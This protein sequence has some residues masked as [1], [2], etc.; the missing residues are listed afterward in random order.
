MNKIRRGNRE[1]SRLFG[2][3]MV[4]PA[5]LLLVVVSII[6]LLDEILSSIWI[7]HSLRVCRCAVFLHIRNVDRLAAESGYPVQRRFQS[8]YSGAL[9]R[10]PG[11][12][13]YHLVL[14]AERQGGL[15]QYRAPE[16]RHD[17]RTDL[18]SVRPD[19]GEGNGYRIRR[20]EIL[21]VYDDH[22]AG[23]HAVHRWC[24]L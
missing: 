12:G 2:Y 1:G 10:A 9:G 14:A 17:S 23:G 6:P 21:S 4:V 13:H 22:L 11:S 24:A 5:T 16:Y 8:D 20:L 3:L 15:N 7:Y 18:F 19:S